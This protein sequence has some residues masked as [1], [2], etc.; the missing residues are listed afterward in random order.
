MAK[1]IAEDVPVI[2][3]REPIIYTLVRPW[4]HNYKYH[5]IAS[6]VEKYVRIDTET[7]MKAKGRG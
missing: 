3:L 6:G 5:P 7:R 2:L 4:A 1:M